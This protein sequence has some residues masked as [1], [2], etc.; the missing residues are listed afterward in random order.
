VYGVF[1]GHGG[2]NVADKLQKNFT[3]HLS[4]E[5]K[6]KKLTNENIKTAFTSF[7]ETLRTF[8]EVGSCAIVA[9]IQGNELYLV[10]LGDSRGLLFNHEGKILLE[11]KDHKPGDPD[12]KKRIELAGGF[13]QTF[14]VPRVNGN[15]ALSRA[16]GDFA[17]KGPVGKNPLT[18][19]PVSSVPDVYHIHLSKGNNHLKVLLACDGLWDI[20]KSQQVVDELLK[21]EEKE[22]QKACGVIVQ[23]AFD[24]GSTDNITALLVE[25]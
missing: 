2:H 25:L 22:M 4:K 8:Y 15:L 17:L 1:D 6:D 5:L 23:R 16:F 3:N 10:N 12:E 9:L 21:V 19:Y 13:V 7:D 14:G 20:Y 24:R 11:T 18:E